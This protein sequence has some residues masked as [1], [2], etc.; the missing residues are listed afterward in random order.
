MI[1]DLERVGILVVNLSCRVVQLHGQRVAAHL[2]GCGVINLDVERASTKFDY[3]VR[4]LHRTNPR[5]DSKGAGLTVGDD[6]PNAPGAR[7]RDQDVVDVLDL[8]DRTLGLARRSRGTRRA[9]DLGSCIGRCLCFRLSLYPKFDR[10]LEAGTQCK[11]LGCAFGRSLC[12]ALRGATRRRGCESV[13]GAGGRSRSLCASPL[14]LAPCL[15]RSRSI[16]RCLGRSRGGVLEGLDDF[17]RTLDD[18]GLLG[19][20]LALDHHLVIAVRVVIPA[21]APQ[22]EHLALRVALLVPHLLAG[23]IPV[24]GV[25]ASALLELDALALLGAVALA[26]AARLDVGERPGVG[27]GIDGCP[28]RDE[29][30]VGR[31]ARALARDGR[32]ASGLGRGVAG[33]RGACRE[34]G[35]T[36]HDGECRDDADDVTLHDVLPGR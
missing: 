26:H 7:V 6:S 16:H 19:C 3:L 34:R 18:D 21:I 30:L 24:G 20:L 11:R 8:Y 17:D 5:R 22:L 33:D 28:G 32:S 27:L 23:V 12:A 2:G 1:A 25:V 9:A 4:L 29:S 10:A 13:R 35:D 14:V 15:G 36:H 31:R